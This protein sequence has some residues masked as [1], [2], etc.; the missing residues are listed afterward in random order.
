MWK[1]I[2]GYEQYSVSDSGE[3]RNNITGKILKQ[4]I[5][6]DGY[7]MVTLHNSDSGKKRWVGVGRL[8]AEE[9]IPN[10][11]NYSQVNHK[12]ED[13]SNN[14]VEN[15]EWCTASYNTNYGTR[16]SRC[17]AKMGK[18]VYQFKDNEL[19]GIWQSTKIAGRFCS[20]SP[21][22]IAD[23]A[24]GLKNSAGGYKWSYVQPLNNN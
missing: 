2:E 21:T 15:L 13:K 22:N 20:I 19:V 10:P 8:V 5:D 18:M 11:N 9:F 1:T 16:N 24:R 17:A 3:V 12:D 6:K 7:Y 23:C 14:S 4:T